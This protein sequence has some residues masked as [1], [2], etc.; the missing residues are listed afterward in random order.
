MQLLDKHALRFRVK[1]SNLKVRTLSGEQSVET[2]RLELHPD[3][4]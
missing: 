4:T 1:R 3:F 2:G